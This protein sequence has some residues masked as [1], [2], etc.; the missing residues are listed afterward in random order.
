MTVDDDLTARL[1]P[2]MTSEV[3]GIVDAVRI[4]NIG[5]DVAI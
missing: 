4:V 2:L 5:M 1:L 3:I